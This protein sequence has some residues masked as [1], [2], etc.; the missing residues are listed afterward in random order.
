MLYMKFFKRSSFKILIGY[1][2]IVLLII[3]ITFVFE[4]NNLM[5]VINNSLILFFILFSD[6]IKTHFYNLGKRLQSLIGLLA[7]KDNDVIM[8]GRDISI[9]AK[10]CTKMASSKTG[11][12][13][14]LERNDDLSEYKKIGV[15]CNALLSLELL[16][17]IFNKDSAL[18]D[19]AVII[20]NNTIDFAGCFF[21]ITRRSTIDKQYGSRHRAAIGLT[22]QCDAVIILISEESGT[23]HIVE[24]GIV[25]DAIFEKDL[26]DKIATFLN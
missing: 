13:I 2:F 12:L 4:E 17:T 8:S 23:I 14:C 15:E 24:G 5:L 18:H 20:Q 16:T 25:S 3:G 11:A 10:S 6:H 21:P 22:E 19:G 7:F 26:A 1:L 9:I